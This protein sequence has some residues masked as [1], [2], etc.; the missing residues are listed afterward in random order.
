[1]Y[2]NNNNNNME[3]FPLTTHV[4]VIVREERFIKEL[5]ALQEIKRTAGGRREHTLVQ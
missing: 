4:K 5:Q 3:C 1:M 2:N